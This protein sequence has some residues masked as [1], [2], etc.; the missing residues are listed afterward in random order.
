MG[1][2]LCS[3]WRPLILACRKPTCGGGWAGGQGV[4]PCFLYTHTQ[5]PAAA[6]SQ[7]GAPAHLAGLQLQNLLLPPARLHQRE[8]QQVEAWLLGGPQAQ[9]G[10]AAR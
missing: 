3:S 8:Q 6:C 1:R 4:G 7:A 10:G 9:R 2:L 5:P